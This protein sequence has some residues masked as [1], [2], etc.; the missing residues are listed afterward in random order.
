MDNLVAES[1]DRWINSRE[2]ERELD[3]M[4][5]PS[6][7]S[8]PC[9]RK[10]I[11]E[12]RQIP[13]SDPPDE[14]TKRILALGKVIHRLVQDAVAGDPRVVQ[15]IPE[16]EINDGDVTGK[17]D[18]LLFRS[19]T[20]TYE[21]IEV[22]SIKLIGIRYGI[23]KPE[24][25]IQAGTYARVLKSNGGVSEGGIIIPPLGDSLTKVRFVYVVKETM[26]FHEKVEDAD[27]LA[28]LAQERLDY[29][30]QFEDKELD[31]LPRVNTRGQWFKNYCPYRSSGLCCGG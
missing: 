28:A 10:A 2:E 3:G 9:V 13:F 8:T 18:I 29:L 26:E 24:H 14:A 19:D 7:I 1:V 20:Q 23:P 12:K 11:M 30:R 27:D 22:K 6:S 17:A 21:L 5:H 16:I 31:Q 15:A 4:W 25:R